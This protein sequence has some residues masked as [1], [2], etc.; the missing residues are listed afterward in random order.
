M[1]YAFPIIISL[2][3]G[4]N[5]FAVTAE[6]CDD[7]SLLGKFTSWVS[8]FNKK[9]S[10]GHS[11]SKQKCPDH[12]IGNVAK[13]H[14]PGAKFLQKIAQ[15]EILDKALQRDPRVIKL[16]ETDPRLK[17]A[18]ARD[19][20]LRACVKNGPTLKYLLG[21]DAGVREGYDIGEHS[22][23]VINLFLE[24]KKFFPNI[25]VKGIS[26]RSVNEL[27]LPILAL[28]DIGKGIAVKGGN[29]DLQHHYTTEFVRTYL[30]S[31]RY[32]QKE[33]NLAVALID[34][35]S[36]GSFLKGDT[37]APQ[38]RQKLQQRA[39]LAGMKYDNFIKLQQLF[40]TADSAS[41]PF[42]RN[43]VFK[44]AKTGQL[45]FKDPKF[46]QLL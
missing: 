41:Y 9:A 21:L 8:S 22:A 43:L 7:P 38:A 46:K 4:Q 25:D 14:S 44:K 10:S 29:K 33:I 28:H 39:K 5:V 40:Y 30:K 15:I 24:Q 12:L 42:L 26:T 13:D 32:S 11:Q 36:V 27:L 6:N 23:K 17:S 45:Q 1:K 35:D 19:R 34:H 20:D 37:S 31:I 2:C 16:L 18:K 3:L